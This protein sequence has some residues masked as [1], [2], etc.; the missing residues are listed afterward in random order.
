MK[1]FLSVAALLGLLLGACSGRAAPT[2]DP[3]H[4]VASAQA[5]A[6][7]IVA[8]TAAAIPPT[9][10][11]TDTPQPSPTPPASATISLPTVAPATAA[12]SGGGGCVHPLSLGEAGPKHPTVVKNQTTATISVSLNLYEPNLF[13]ECGALVISGLAKNDSE[14]IGLPSGNWYIYAWSTGGKG[15]HIDGTIYIQPSFMD[16]LELCIR[17]NVIKYAQVC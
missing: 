10:T 14:S 2:V 9:P 17:T 6:N 4:V 3:A 16:K 12:Q 8:Q 15:F 5:A 1:S 7:T 13:G 11:V